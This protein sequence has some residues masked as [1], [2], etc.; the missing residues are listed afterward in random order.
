MLYQK[1]R[2]VVPMQWVHLDYMRKKTDATFN[3]ILEACEF[4]GISY[5]LQFW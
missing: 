2:H 4:R 3:K 5:I 1:T